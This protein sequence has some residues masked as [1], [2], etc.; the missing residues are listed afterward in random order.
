QPFF[1]D[2]LLSL[3]IQPK[4]AVSAGPH[5]KDQFSWYFRDQLKGTTNLGWQVNPN[6]ETILKAKPDLILSSGIHS[7]A[8]ENFSKIAPTGLIE[9][10]ETEGGKDWRKTF[11]ST[12]VVFG[13]EEKAKQVIAEYDQQVEESK[14]KIR[15]AIGNET[16]MFLRVKD[17]ELR[18]Y[19]QKNFDVMYGDL[20][21]KPPAHFPSAK[22][23]QPFQPLALEKLPEINPDHIFLLVETSETFNEISNS[24]IWKNLRAVKNRRV[25]EVDYDLWQQGFGPIAN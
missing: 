1:I 4:A 5:A 16:V 9:Q 6:L 22:G 15:R 20:G 13:K 17:K 18:Y 11:L 21:L 24:E 19:G 10:V 8:Y 2:F 12:A 25:Y 23:E 3:G 14:K 7:E